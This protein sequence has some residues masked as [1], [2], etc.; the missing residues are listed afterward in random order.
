MEK[1]SRWLE[2]RSDEVS[3]AEVERNIT[4]TAKFVR[5][6]IDELIH[7]GY[8]VETAGLRGSRL[9]RSVKPYRET[10]SSDLVATSSDEVGEAAPLTSSARRGPTGPDEDEV[11]RLAEVARAE[12]EEFSF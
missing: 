8:A 12:L 3:R 4:G 1:V 5:I 10:T 2:T 6:A 7:D 11:E 9:V